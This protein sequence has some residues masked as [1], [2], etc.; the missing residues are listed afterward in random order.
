[1]KVGHP[2][3]PGNWHARENSKHRKIQ[4]R[5]DRTRARESDLTREVE[6]TYQSTFVRRSC[7]WHCACRVYMYMRVHISFSLSHP[8][9]HSVYTLSHSI[10]LCLYFFFFPTRRINGNLGTS[11]GYRRRDFAKIDFGTWSVVGYA[12]RRRWR[13]RW[14]PRNK[15]IGRH[16]ASG[17]GL[18]DWDQLIPLFR[19]LTHTRKSALP[20][21]IDTPSLPREQPPIVAAARGHE[22]SG[23]P[24]GG[25]RCPVDRGPSIGIRVKSRGEAYAHRGGDTHR[26]GE[27]ARAYTGYPR[28]FVVNAKIIL[29]QAYVVVLVPRAP[30]ARQRRLLLVHHRIEQLQPIHG[31]AL[32]RIPSPRFHNTPFIAGGGHHCH[33]LP[34]SRSTA[35]VCVRSWIANAVAHVAPRNSQLSRDDTLLPLRENRERGMRDSETLLETRV[36]PARLV[37]ALLNCHLF[38]SASHEPRSTTN[39]VRSAILLR[40]L[41]WTRDW[42]ILFIHMYVCTQ[43]ECFGI[44]RSKL[45]IY[46]LFYFCRVTLFALETRWLVLSGIEGKKKEDKNR[47][48]IYRRE[49]GSYLRGSQ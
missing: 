13:R 32:P 3:Y 33:P 28:T 29:R 40:P 26:L 42:S 12:T 39:R 18:A 6:S 10:S 2:V 34:H 23:G 5:T 19:S 21:S 15:A 7:H 8:L 45:R 4:L 25:G 48:R 22:G 38:R 1:M 16:T 43:H 20:F 27:V 37:P 30:G 46:F 31:L 35:S 47:E 41:H 24:R 17:G 36:P 14:R 9:S 49:C 44:K 11:R